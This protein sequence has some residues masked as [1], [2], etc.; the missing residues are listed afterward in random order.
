MLDADL[1][2]AGV[3]IFPNDD[4]AREAGLA[5]GNGIQVAQA[6]G[7]PDPD[8]FAAGD[9]ANAYHPVLGYS[10]RVEHSMNA[11]Q[12]GTLA[13]GSMLGDNTAYDRL[14]YFYSDQYDSGMEYVGHVGPGGYDQV[15]FRGDPSTGRYL[16][17][18]LAG[19]VIRAGMNVDVWDVNDTIAGLI[20]A[21]RTVNARQLAD[22]DIPLPGYECLLSSR[23]SD[24]EG[25]R[26]DRSA[27]AG[28]LPSRA[29]RRKLSGGTGSHRRQR[30]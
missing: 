22:Q 16:A 27:H 28:Q 17:F 5:T 21:S 2:V 11:I 14:P 3:G 6:L 10:I 20:R 23:R 8:I 1:V 25:S 18:W 29:H 13:A 30:G 7:T 24:Q 4:L 19:D 9:V 26:H 12:Q 15:V